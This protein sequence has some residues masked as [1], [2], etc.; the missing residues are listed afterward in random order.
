MGETPVE[1]VGVQAEASGDAPVVADEVALDDSGFVDFA[2]AGTE[3]AGEFRCAECGY[4]AVVQ[5]A[6]PQCPMCGGTVWES[7]RPL[8]QR[9]GR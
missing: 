2:A 9:P 7:R 3:V 6:L 8:A 1:Q 5:R 4:G